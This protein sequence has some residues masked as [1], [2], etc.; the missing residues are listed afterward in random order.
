MSP[1]YLRY[2]FPSSHASENAGVPVESAKQ[3]AELFL[4]TPTHE[5]TVGRLD[6]IACTWAYVNGDAGGLEYT[7]GEPMGEELSPWLRLIVGPG[8]KK[9][10]LDV[11][12]EEMGRMQTRAFGAHLLEVRR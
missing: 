3:L 6:S 12:V 8:G 5:L 4:E 11:D 9:A 10:W 1:R 7:E 2:R